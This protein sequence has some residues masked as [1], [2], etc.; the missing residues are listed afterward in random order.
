MTPVKR[1]ANSRPPGPAPVRHPG[2][3]SLLEELDGR[4][5]QL[6]GAIVAF[7]SA[8]ADQLGLGVTDL[9]AIDLLSRHATVTAGELA[10]MSGLT[11]GAVTGLLDRL[12]R[13]A[14]IVRQKD[15]DDA[16]RL[17]VRLRG[18]AGDR[19]AVA[20]P[21]RSVTRA[22]RAVASSFTDAELATI[23]DFMSRSEG[24]LREQAEALGERDAPGRGARRVRRRGTGGG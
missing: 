8:A 2:H 23:L 12:E 24:V 14:M 21:I 9:K 1:P 7:Q 20:A 6:S 11:A 4:W 13:A 16:R 5:R 10:A 22:L 19:G 15:P 17:V 18:S 3:E